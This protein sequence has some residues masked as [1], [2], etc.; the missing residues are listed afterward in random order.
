MRIG[1]WNL[2]G[3]WSDRHLARLE[4]VDCGVWLLTE[5]HDHLDLPGYS[6]HVTGSPM[7]KHV[8]WSGI[9]SRTTLEPCPDPH[10]ASAMAR[11]DGTTFV[12]SVL[13][14]R[15]SGGAHPW[16][17]T[18]HAERTRQTISA[19]S[20]NVPAGGLVWGGDWN[21]AL[22]GKEY[23]GS[24]GGR[25]AVVD[26]AL[27]RDLSVLTAD[28]P[29]ALEGLLSIDH[30]AVPSTWDVLSAERVSATDDTARLSDHDLYVVDTDA[31]GRISSTR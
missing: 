20:R 23:A 8:Q 4:S 29:H 24:K 13:P 19:L 2:A 9:F 16:H 1:T 25:E 7:R 21:H 17:G 18:N 10:P 31:G 6:G 15:S 22:S 27:Q 5:V 3:R 11:V 14:W 28:L 12:S 30:I 26:A